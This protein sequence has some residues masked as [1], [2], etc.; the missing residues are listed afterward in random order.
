MAY[1]ESGNYGTTD[2]R[3][4]REIKRSRERT[5]FL[6]AKRRIQAF[7]KRRQQEMAVEAATEKFAAKVKAA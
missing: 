3:R 4:N 1:R 7:R 2:L 5:K 6:F